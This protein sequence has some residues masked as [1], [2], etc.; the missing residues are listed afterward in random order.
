MPHQAGGYNMITRSLKPQNDR[1]VAIIKELY[2]VEKLSHVFS[3]L[4]GLLYEDFYSFGCEQLVRLYDKWDSTKGANFSTWVNRNL[5]LLYFNYLRDQSR[6]VRLPRAITALGVRVGRE[7]RLNPNI[8]N[9]QLCEICGC[10]PEQ[11]MEVEIALL[12]TYSLD[13][14]NDDED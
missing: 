2:K 1:D 14:D 9:T 8:S 7:K 10:T 6:M 5:R 11:L 12:P 3:N 13:F 4:T